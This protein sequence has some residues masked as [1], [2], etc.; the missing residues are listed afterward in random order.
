MVFLR[1]ANPRLSDDGAARSWYTGADVN[2]AA[3]R[4]RGRTRVLQRWENDEDANLLD[5][6]ASGRGALPSRNGIENSLTSDSV[7]PLDAYAAELLNGAHTGR[8]LPAGLR[9]APGGA[10]H[11]SAKALCVPRL[12]G[13]AYP[14]LR[15]GGHNVGRI[16][17]GADG[18]SR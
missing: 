17:K 16:D 1:V 3:R 9:L 14:A 15:L 4:P 2:E 6:T 13:A 12:A 5:W 7:G 18:E 8:A 10:S 11:A